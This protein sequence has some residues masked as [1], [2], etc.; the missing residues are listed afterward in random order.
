MEG[1]PAATKIA[2]FATPCR[3]LNGLNLARCRR[4]V[5][6]GSLTMTRFTNDQPNLFWPVLLVA[7]A[8]GVAL[9]VLG[10]NSFDTWTMP[11]E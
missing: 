11:C 5:H 7:V 6:R 1:G 2:H 10:G 3:P 8:F 9:L 4:V